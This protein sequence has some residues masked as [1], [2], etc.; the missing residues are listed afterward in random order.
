MI[1][2]LEVPQQNF[3]RLCQQGWINNLEF[4]LRHRD[5]ST[6]WVSLTA[7]ALKDS[8]GNFLMSRSTM[9]D[10]S[11]RKRAE[12]ERQQQTQQ[13]QLLWS[14]TQAIRQSLELRTIL[15][16]AVTEVRQLL[17]VDRATVYRFNPDWSG[18]FIV[19][20]VV[21]GWVKLV[22]PGICKFWEDTYLQ[23][24]QGG[25]FKNHQT[26]TVTDIY[27]ADLQPCHINLLEQFQARA[28][29][30]APIFVG[31]LLW[32]LFAL[33]HNTTPHTWEPWE[34]E[35]LQQ[36]ADQLAIVIQQSDLYTQLQTELQERDKIDRMKAEFISIVS[37][38]LR[39]PLTSM[40]A[41][42]SLLNEKMIDP[43]SAEGEAT[44]QIATDGTDRL[45]R[46]VNDILDLERL[47]SGKVR[48]E[49]FYY[50]IH[51]LVDTAVAQ[52]QEMANQAGIMLEVSCDSIQLKVDGDRLIQVLTNLLSN[53]I[54]FSPSESVVRL[55]VAQVALADAPTHLQ[56]TVQDEGRGIP[57]DMLE[58]IFDRFHQVDASDSRIKGGTG[59]GLA[60]CRSIAQ[61]HGGAI[62]AESTLGQGSRF[63]FTIPLLTE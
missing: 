3:P 12:A 16:T 48:L 37:H 53:A 29:A 7:T 35:L 33:Y 11:D 23:E 32:G 52:M 15:T 62:W 59:L 61:Q 54:K 44:I 19:E 14:I 6:R 25:R 49:K 20:S 56:F 30:V 40:Q 24:H 51:H 50:D 41:A 42:L 9:F 18:D 1:I 2:S 13:K 8:A 45:V 4:E 57:A 34:I 27:T 21:E 43:T 47:E 55:S 5:G 63:C 17:T 46:L 60:I 39:T 58:R 38:E 36:I 10:I 31:N 26:L 22:E 28:Y